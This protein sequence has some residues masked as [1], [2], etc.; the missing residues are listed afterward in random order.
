MRL[1]PI[2]ALSPERVREL[3]APCYTEA[4]PAGAE[5]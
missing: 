5:E 1:E 4:V 2:A 3:A